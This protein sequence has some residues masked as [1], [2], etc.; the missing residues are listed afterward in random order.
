MSDLE[1][2]YYDFLKNNELL[3]SYNEQVER[4]ESSFTND[5]IKQIVLN[6]ISKKYE[7]DDQLKGIN[8][9]ISHLFTSLLSLSAFPEMLNTGFYSKEDIEAHEKASKTMFINSFY[10]SAFKHFIDKSDIECVQKC[11]ENAKKDG[12]KEEQINTILDKFGYADLVKK[13]QETK[14]DDALDAL[15]KAAQSL[16]GKKV[17]QEAAAKLFQ[18][19]ADNFKTNTVD[20][21]IKND[22]QTEVVFSA[23]EENLDNELPKNEKNPDNEIPESVESDN[24]KAD[25]TKK[26]IPSMSKIFDPN[27][28][29]LDNI[30]RLLDLQSLPPKYSQMQSL[31]NQLIQSGISN[32][33][34]KEYVEKYINDKVVGKY[35]VDSFKY[36]KALAVK[37]ACENSDVSEKKYSAIALRCFAKSMGN[38]QK[39]SKSKEEKLEFLKQKYDIFRKLACECVKCG[40]DKEV[41]EKIVENYDLTIDVDKMFKN[42]PEIMDLLKK[43]EEAK[44]K[45]ELEKIFSSDADLLDETEDIT[46]RDGDLQSLA[47][48]IKSRKFA[49]DNDSLTGGENKQDDLGDKYNPYSEEGIVAKESTTPEERIGFGRRLKSALN[50]LWNGKTPEI[51]DGKGGK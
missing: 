23:R 37:C 4:I 8:H 49:T 12:M 7:N 46:L 1:K 45:Q 3:T 32:K 51:K 13:E 44:Q 33:D 19:L 38:V 35:S 25:D 29:I 15:I 22:K 48:E 40:N 20:N 47:S 24:K 2:K 30:Q 9:V 16:K 21:G 34:L 27:A 31:I 14:T 11:I 42:Y 50:I 39:S 18:Q 26:G 17:D 41:V 5:E 6:T 43:R 10:I 28:N 36:L